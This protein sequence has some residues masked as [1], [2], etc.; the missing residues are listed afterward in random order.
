[1]A[2]APKEGDHTASILRPDSVVSQILVVQSNR[3]SAELTA[4]LLRQ[5]DSVYG[6]DT[7]ITL[8]G[9]RET[10]AST[11]VHLV[12]VRYSSDLD[13][14][15]DLVGE[16]TPGTYV[17]VTDVPA[18]PLDHGTV[19]EEVDATILGTRG[20]SGLLRTVEEVLAPH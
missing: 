1:M 10:L 9:V 19:P 12:L 20:A 16:E 15:L 4:D 5:A 17:V 18:G 14:V 7:A 8:D 3:I 11:S 13:R 6:V 2:I